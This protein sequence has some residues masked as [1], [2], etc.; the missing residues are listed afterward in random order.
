[1]KKGCIHLTSILK[2]KKYGKKYGRVLRLRDLTK[3]R[4]VCDWFIDYQRYNCWAIDVD[5]KTGIAYTYCVADE[6]GFY[7][8]EVDEL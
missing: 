3:D 4:S 7:Y 1:M 5:T 6:E 8:L 2:E